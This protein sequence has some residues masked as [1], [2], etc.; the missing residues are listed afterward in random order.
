MT[1]TTKS[2]VKN[3]PKKTTKTVVKKSDTNA[4]KPR[5]PAKKK[6]TKV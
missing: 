4:K 2:H 5:V 6:M 3:T 1:S